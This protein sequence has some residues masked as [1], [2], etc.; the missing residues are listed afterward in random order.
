[1]LHGLQLSACKET[2]RLAS[3]QTWCRYLTV[4]FGG[5]LWVLRKRPCRCRSTLALCEQYENRQLQIHLTPLRD[6]STH[7]VVKVCILLHAAMIVIS[8]NHT[9]S[10]F[11]ARLLPFKQLPL[12]AK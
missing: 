11:S 5:I 10:L 2:Y 8:F 4:V 1:M 9:A 3:L 7:L 12:I 6:Y